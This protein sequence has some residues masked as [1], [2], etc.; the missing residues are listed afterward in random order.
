[1]TDIQENTKIEKREVLFTEEQIQ[2]RVTELAD[3]I[4]KDVDENI[5][6][7][8]GVLNG[9][10]FFTTDLASTFD[11]SNVQID[12]ISVSSYGGNTESSRE[13]VIHCDLKNPIEGRD[14]IIVEDIVDTGYSMAILLDMLKARQ[15]KSIRVCT[16]LSKPS[17]REIDV[18]IDY[19]GFEIDNYWVEGYGLDTKEKCRCFRYITRRI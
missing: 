12:F 14:V 19:V 1:M 8:V 6:T 5:L 17:R 2:A 18:P 13:P 16:L 10:A 4:K 15:P 7:L 11:N 9:A 3:E